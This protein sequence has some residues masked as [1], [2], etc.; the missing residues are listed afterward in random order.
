M[1]FPTAAGPV[2]VVVG[3]AL[4]DLLTGDRSVLNVNCSVATSGIP[5]ASTGS[6]LAPSPTQLPTG[7]TSQQ[8]T[9]DQVILRSSDL[10]D[11]YATEFRKM[12]EAKQFGPNKAKGV[13]HPTITLDG[14]PADTPALIEKV[15]ELCATAS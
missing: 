5:I 4:F 13:P 3:A 9:T 2:P 1:G 7:V 15:R 14:A 8:L 12:F 6:G 10:A 11:N